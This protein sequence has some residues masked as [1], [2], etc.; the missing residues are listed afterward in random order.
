MP[1]QLAVGKLW[2]RTWLKKKLLESHL[3]CTVAIVYLKWHILTIYPGLQF[4]HLLYTLY[5]TLYHWTIT[6]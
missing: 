6:V 2:A 4:T 3:L 5:Y 1:T